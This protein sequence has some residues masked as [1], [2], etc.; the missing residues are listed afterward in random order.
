MPSW[1]DLGATFNTLREIDVSVIREESE[2]P[3]TIA[4][5]GEQPALALALGLLNTSASRRYGPVGLNPLLIATLGEVQRRGLATD[6]GAAIRQADLLLIVL[7]G[8][9]PVS[10]AAAATLR[11]LADLALPTVI[12]LC[13]TTTPPI[14]AGDTRRAFAFAHVVALPDPES[15]LAADALAGALLERLP[16]ELHMA[17]A[18]RLPGL[19]PAYAR[20][21]INATSF[22]NASYAL[23]SALPEQI[24]IFSLPFAAADILVLTKNQAMLVYKLALAH[25]APPEFQ[26]RIREVLPVL[27]GAF[28]WRQLARTLVGLVPVWGVVPKVA[29]AYAGTYSTGV[30]AWR[31]FDSGE[32]ISGA[33]LKEVTD[34]ALRVGRERAQALAD[35]ARERGVSGGG[36]LSRLTGRIRQALPG[37]KAAPAAPPEPE[38]PEY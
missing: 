10:A 3:V 37:R 27:G 16:G 7:D 20:Q 19:R 32:L 9:A 23:A 35:A 22:T 13:H 38:P 1:N 4:C 36:A 5:V 33:R 12:A 2:Q 15:P 29:I 28:A 21:L 31:W 8:R 11:A 18:R 30:V 26:A 34:E 24:P 14:P 6:A 17:A 25:G